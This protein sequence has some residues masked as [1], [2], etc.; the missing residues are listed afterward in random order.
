MHAYIP[1]YIYEIGMG[2]KDGA[3]SL[4]YVEYPPQQTSFY[5]KLGLVRLS[6]C[7][8]SANEGNPYKTQLRIGRMG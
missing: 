4:K 5:P 6:Y 2:I 7:P 1:I 8:V 3:L